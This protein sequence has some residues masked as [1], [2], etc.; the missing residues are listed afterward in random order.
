MM[1]LKPQGCLAAAGAA[2]AGQSW[3][4]LAD[5]TSRM[6]NCE[7]SCTHSAWLSVWPAMHKNSLRQC[8]TE[9]LP[10]LLLLNKCLG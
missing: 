5:V 6:C 8:L 3:R 9:A 4:Q 1:C 2:A 10:Y 7:V